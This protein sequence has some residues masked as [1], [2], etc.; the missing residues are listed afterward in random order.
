M[1]LAVGINGLRV[2]PAQTGERA[3]CPL[4][5]RRVIAKVGELVCPHWAHESL[6]D[7]DAW[8][9]GE[10]PWHQEWKERFP[11]QYREV[12]MGAHR[13]DIR[14]PE[15][16]VIEFQHSGIAPA[17]MR[18]REAFYRRMA[19]VFDTRESYQQERLQL[20]D[21]RTHVS[22]SWKRA[23][24]IIIAASQP[25]F[26]DL[27]AS[28]LVEVRKYY[29]SNPNDFSARDEGEL[30]TAPVQPARIAGGWGYLRTADWFMAHYCKCGSE[31]NLS[32][33]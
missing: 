32:L 27:G 11:V 29:P 30:K 24:R 2:E 10:T 13:A 3:M 25:V 9:E 19:W 17:E 28:G 15:G 1:M 22:F 4:C 18:E 20:K 31:S 6:E 21:R 7:C 5:Q 23:R 16:L 26:L 33:F 14:L 12:V 8:S